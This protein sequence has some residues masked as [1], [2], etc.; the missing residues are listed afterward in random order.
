MIKG[1]EVGNDILFGCGSPSKLRFYPSATPMQWHVGDTRENQ[2]EFKRQTIFEKVREIVLQDRANFA[3]SCCTRE[4]AKLE[5]GSWGLRA[6]VT[7]SQT[8]FAKM[9]ESSSKDN[10]SIAVRRRTS[11]KMRDA[12]PKNDNWSIP[13]PELPQFPSMFETVQ[14]VCS[15]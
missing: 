7:G 1:L 12:P 4:P 6:S 9:M 11:S 3:A 5:R 15:F 14:N 8:P 13:E 10:S 2:I